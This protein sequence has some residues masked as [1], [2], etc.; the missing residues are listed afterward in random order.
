MPAL[1]PLHEV[2]FRTSRSGGPGGQ[3]V[4]KVESRVEARWNVRGS[5]ALDEEERARL[6]AALAPRLTP[7]GL[8]RV[9]CQ[10]FRSQARNREG[11]LARLRELVAAALA[12]RRKRRR[13]AA[14]ERAHRERIEE[15]KRRGATKRLRSAPAGRS[16]HGDD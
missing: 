11:A 14:P 6:L 12:P 3:N 7:D 16:R 13:T 1:V 4:N 10:R 5:A 9:T 15:K 2:E 8:L